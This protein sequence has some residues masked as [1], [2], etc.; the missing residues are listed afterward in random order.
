M[1]GFCHECGAPRA[2][3][4]VF[5]EQCGASLRPLGVL[6]PP[7]ST[8]LP[9]THPQMPL[10]DGRSGPK[11]GPVAEPRRPVQ[12]SRRL[13]IGGA[14]GVLALLLAGGG[15]WWWLAPRPAT[16]AL[17]LDCVKPWLT[18]EGLNRLS[19][20][21]LSNFD[22][23]ASPVGIN[24][25]NASTREWRDG[26]FKAGIYQGTEEVRTGNV[27]QPLQLRY[28]KTPK[29]STSIVDGRLC[30]ASRL[31]ALGL[32]FNPKEEE[33]WGPM[34]IQRGVLK[35]RWEDR[36]AWSDSEPFKSEFDRQFK[37]EQESLVW[38]AQDKGWRLMTPL[39]VNAWT[40][41]RR[42]PAGLADAEQGWLSKL[43]SS[44]DTPEKVAESMLRAMM[45]RD[46]DT[47]AK[48]AYSRELSRE[49]IRHRLEQAPSQTKNAGELDYVLVT[50]VSGD[51]SRTV[52]ELTARMKT[53]E[54]RFLTLELR[55]ID[56]QWRVVMGF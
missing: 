39:E 34:R 10:S 42:H 9:K 29:A 2:V 47:M 53:G 1:T 38:V 17:L 41:A 54:T 26:L 28:E 46:L 31:E 56:H 14:G 55:S 40:T 48:L 52:M 5:C 23:R 33:H 22:Y 25:D 8:P 4:G 43:F 13:L 45:E 36:A 37:D 20:P 35:V 12:I 30:A 32:E 11:Q 19:R 6:R 24:P 49:E 21:C 15:A 16:E 18:G 50:R 3:A 27:W 44:G 7:P 51:Q